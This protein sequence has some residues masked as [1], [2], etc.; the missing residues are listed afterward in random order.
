[1]LNKFISSSLTIVN[2]KCN[3]A[4]ICNRFRDNCGV[5]EIL[6]VEVLLLVLL[7]DSWIT[8]RI[9]C[10]GNIEI[11]HRHPLRPCRDALI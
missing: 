11:S 9:V 8:C 4:R 10:F 3:F 2:R 7:L 6:V 1:M 5:I